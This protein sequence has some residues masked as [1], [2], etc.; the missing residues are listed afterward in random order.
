MKYSRFVAMKGLSQSYVSFVVAGFY[1][2]TLVLPHVF[3]KKLP[4][5][6]MS[7]LTAVTFKSRPYFCPESTAS[8]LF[9]ILSSCWLCVAIS[10]YYFRSLVFGCFWIPFDTFFKSLL[11]I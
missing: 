11:F 4:V 1:G 2:A 10:L 7:R 3:V 5:L 9:D 8:L 6:R